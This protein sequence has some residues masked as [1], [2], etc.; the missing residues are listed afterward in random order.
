[1]LSRG[2]VVTVAREH[3]DMAEGQPIRNR[4]TN[5]MQERGGGRVEKETPGTVCARGQSSGYGSLSCVGCQC[6]G[7]RTCA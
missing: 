3:E 1:M 6:G 4:S 5:P 7:D 2:S